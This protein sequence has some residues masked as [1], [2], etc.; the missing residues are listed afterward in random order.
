VSVRVAV[1]ASSPVVRAGLEHLLALGDDV[2]VVGTAATRE[3]LGDLGA[4]DIHVLVLDDDTDTRLSALRTDTADDDAR[5]TPSVVLLVD[6]PTPTLARDAIAVGVRA[7]LSRDAGDAELIAAVRAVAAGL[8]VLTPD[9]A[10]PVRGQANVAR[11]EG[12]PRTVSLTPR[13]HEVLQALAEGL[14][15]KQVAARLGISEHTIKTHVTAVFE[16]LGVTTRAEAV[17]R[18]VQLGVLML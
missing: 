2:V 8:V 14:A 7:L 15:N 5:G 1:V 13:E 16:K 17:A 12:S 18:G 9:A 11:R 4:S 3:A 6:E 10:Q